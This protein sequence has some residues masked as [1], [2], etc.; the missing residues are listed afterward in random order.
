MERGQSL[1]TLLF[2][3]HCSLSSCC[4]ATMD[5]CCQYHCCSFSSRCHCSHNYQDNPCVVGMQIL[6]TQLRVI[7]WL[8]CFCRISL[9]SKSLW[10]KY[11]TQNLE[12]YYSERWKTN[13]NSWL[14][15]IQHMFPSFWLQNEN[16]LFQAPT[17]EY[18]NPI[19][20]EWYKALKNCVHKLKM[21]ISNNFQHHLPFK[22]IYNICVKLIEV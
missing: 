19:Y 15:L 22:V 11:K 20:G 7:V 12:R 17:K 14:T 13:H 1:I 10:R 18:K 2:I 16:P 4:C 9:R 3:L 21:S 5:T 8:A 6:T